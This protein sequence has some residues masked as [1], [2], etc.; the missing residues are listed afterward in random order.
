MRA[1]LLLLALVTGCAKNTEVLVVFSSDIAPAMVKQLKVEIASSAAGAVPY[2]ENA[3]ATPADRQLEESIDVVDYE[4][5]AKGFLVRAALHSGPV[6]PGTLL[7]SRYAVVPFFAERSLRV[8][9]ALDAACLPVVCDPSLT[10]AQGLCVPPT[11]V[12]TEDGAT[13]PSS[14]QRSTSPRA[15]RARCSRPRSI[16]SRAS[17]WRLARRR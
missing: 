3:Y 10:C 2:F 14:L 4:G 9:L 16:R 5:D 1:T 8:E 15:C 6:G 13:T 7:V 12:P 11:V 17:S